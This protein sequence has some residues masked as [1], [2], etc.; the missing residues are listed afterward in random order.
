MS[1]VFVYDGDCAFCSSSARWIQRWVRPR[2]PLV[3]WQHTDLDALGLTQEQCEEAVQWSGS[4]GV[5]AAG[6]A[7]FARLLVDAGRWWRPLGHVL[8]LRP[9]RWLADPVYRLIARNRHRL[10]GGTPQCS[11]PQSLRNPQ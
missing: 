11:L 4:D 9:V 6:P 3:A 2:T 1:A 7:A 8:A 10:P 5:R